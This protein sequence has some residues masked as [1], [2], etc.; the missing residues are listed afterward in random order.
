MLDVSRGKLP[1]ASSNSCI[2]ALPPCWGRDVVTVHSLLDS[3][4]GKRV[5]K[6]MISCFQLYI[7]YLQGIS[8]EPLPSSF[9]WCWYPETCL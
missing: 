7:C 9:F 4:V 1:A 3:E 8:R 5:S 2:P 6:G